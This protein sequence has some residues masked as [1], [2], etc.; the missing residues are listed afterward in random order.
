MSFKSVI[1]QY[2]PVKLAQ[3]YLNKRSFATGLKSSGYTDNNCSLKEEEPKFKNI[4]SVQG[5]GYSG[6]GALV[7]FFREFSDFQVL[8]YV[9]NVKDGGYAPKDQKLSEIDIIRLAGGLFEIERFLDSTNVFHNNALLNRTA[10]AFGS[11]SLYRYSPA[12]RDLMY[13]FFASITCLR[14][15]NLSQSYYNGYL[16]SVGEIQDLYYLKAMKREDYVT[17]CRNFLTSLFNV[18]YTEG[19]DYLAID[20]LLAEEFDVKRNMEYIPN[21]KMVAVARDPRDTY[22]WAIQ[23]DVEWIEHKTVDRFITWYKL[24]Y[25]DVNPK[26]PEEGY[27]LLRYE[28]VVLDYDNQER[29]ILEYLDVNKDSHV[30]RKEYFRPEFSKRFVG[31]FKNVEGYEEDISKIKTVLADYCNPILDKC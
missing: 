14:M 13:K 4:V 22:I 27:L 24:M 25:A 18:F 15:E 30:L 11:S 3:S 8:G 19:K 28:D 6:S 20:Q 5:F 31:L 23:H 12:V 26:Y 1:K 7:D 29:R 10:K 9:D 17:L 21:L 2:L 16:P